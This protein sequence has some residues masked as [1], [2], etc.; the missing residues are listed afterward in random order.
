MVQPYRDG[1]SLTNESVLKKFLK[2]SGDDKY[3]YNENDERN[4]DKLK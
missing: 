4:L 2:D 3:D 1:S